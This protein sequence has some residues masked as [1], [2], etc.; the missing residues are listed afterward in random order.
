MQRILIVEDNWELNKGI[1]YILEKVGYAVNAAHS[2]EE[3]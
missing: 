2:I 1:C 3:A